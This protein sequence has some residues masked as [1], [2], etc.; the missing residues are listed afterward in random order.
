MKM[1]SKASTVLILLTITVFVCSN[2]IAQKQSK[3]I[4][5]GVSLVKWQT[6]SPIQIVGAELG[7]E[8]IVKDV[9]LFNTSKSQV[10]K[11]QFQAVIFDIENKLSKNV[12]DFFPLE[13]NTIDITILPL[14]VVQLKDINLWKFSGVRQFLK[15][16]NSTNY[17]IR[18]GVLYSASEDGTAFES[19]AKLNNFDKTVIGNSEHI[20]I[21]ESWSKNGYNQLINIIN[22]QTEAS[23]INTNMNAKVG[24]NK[25]SG[26]STCY[27]NVDE[28]S[29]CQMK[30]QDSCATFE[31]DPGRSC[32]KTHC[33]RLV[34]LE[35]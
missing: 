12:A 6:N 3:S 26:G 35:Q 5:M 17:I 21:D 9:F 13:S 28:T 10:N 8:N 15:S 16:S 32:P 27:K 30:T 22:K 23:I 24:I 31:C 1:I 25:D 29:W 20:K 7:D 18:L 11:I 34:L 4:Q 14:E 2:A 19:K 33:W